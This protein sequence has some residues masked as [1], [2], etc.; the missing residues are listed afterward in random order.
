MNRAKE[1]SVAHRIGRAFTL[2]ELLIVIGIIALLISLLLPAL[3]QARRS[4]MA[5]KCA[6]NQRQIL[7]AMA[8]YAND[9]NYAIPGS[10]TT[11]G[12]QL[13]TTPP[14]YTTSNCPDRISMWD[15]KTPLAPYMFL[16]YND[17]PSLADRIS[18]L[19][20]LN[21]SDPF[22]C[23]SN[24][25]V[26][27]SSA[28]G[29]TGPVAQ[30]N[31]YATAVMFMYRPEGA[32]IPGRSPSDPFLRLRVIPH[33]NL[34][35]PLGY[36]PS[37]TKIGSAANKAFLADGARYAQGRFPTYTLSLTTSA[38]GDYS[39]YGP[40]SRFANGFMR[41]KA[42]ANIGQAPAGAGLD[43]TRVL[44]ARH[45]TNVPDLA[46]DSYKFNV[47]FFD[48]HVARMGD[49]EGSNPVYWSPS[50]TRIHESEFWNDTKQRFVS[51]DG[52]QNL[53]ASG[54]FKVPD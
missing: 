35:L 46:G 38:G 3:N 47:G 22:L 5:M 4:A 25:D 27:A 33:S 54:F 26:L 52:I 7:Q 6:S 8:Q 20:F 12:L 24:A 2:T 29:P 14:G 34:K 37:I 49:L 36:S 17:G 9:N 28:A 1:P 13:L 45:G 50:G 18:R 19:E 30:W 39:D 53:D 42:P 43:D 16:E 40:F 11:T 51:P 10:P 21:E 31:S 32:T 48:G 41:H 23:P 44:W 15:Y